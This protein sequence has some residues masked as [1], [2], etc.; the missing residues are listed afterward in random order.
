MS[1]L[2]QDSLKHD[3]L[4]KAKEEREEQKAGLDEMVPRLSPRREKDI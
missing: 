2:K 4:V 3:E 1:G